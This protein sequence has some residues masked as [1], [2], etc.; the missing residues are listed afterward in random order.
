M[1]EGQNK[2]MNNINTVGPF[3]VGL[4]DGDGS[5]QVNHWRRKNLQYRMVIKLKNTIT[6]KNMLMFLTQH[7][8]GRVREY[9]DFILWVE[10]IK[11][12][13]VKK[14]FILKEF[15][16]LTKRLKCQI[17]FLENCLLLND[18]EWYFNERGNK[19][20]TNKT[21][22]NSY[23]LAY[24]FPSY[25]NHWLSGFIE[26]E[27]SFSIIKKNR[28]CFSIGQKNEKDLITN[29]RDFFN[30]PNKIIENK[31]FYLVN[32]YKKETLL[33]IIKHCINFPLI[34]EKNESLKNF[35]LY[36]SPAG[37]GSG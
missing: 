1:I 25:Y 18:I 21:Q 5:I 17:E 7:I 8:G 9:H 20:F 6:N 33:K 12:E 2:I 35:I 15:P 23:S 11:K 14:L 31:N 26:A 3:W 24:N 37:G 30:S 34:G 13:I 22:G 27:G 16:P 10:D 36:L 32:I 19:Y 4:M 29:I 28:P